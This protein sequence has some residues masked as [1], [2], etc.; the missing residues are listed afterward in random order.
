MHVYFQRQ[1]MATSAG[2]GISSI[3]GETLEK[4]QRELGENPETRGAIIQELRDKIEQWEPS[5]EEE[6]LT[7]SQKDDQFLLRYLRAKK[8][9]TERALQLYVNY[10]KYRKKYADLLGEITPKAA[11]H[12]LKSGLVSVL[13]ER[14]KS[15]CKVVVI[16]A[17]LWDID[18]MPPQDVLKTYLLL[19]DRLIEE[20]ETQVH[21]FVFFE[22]LSGIDF[23]RIF[24]LARTEQLQKGVVVELLQVH[25][26]PVA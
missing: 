15:G 25:I 3:S 2:D 7:F 23:Y 16:R 13:P 11:E 20:E 14:S 9:D 24:R 21:G 17:E 19:L 26:Q 12:I 18:A 22:D 10:H 1:V 4:A 6:G 5:P 8:F